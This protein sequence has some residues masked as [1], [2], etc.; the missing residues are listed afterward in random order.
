MLQDWVASWDQPIGA[1]IEKYVEFDRNY[2]ATLQAQLLAIH[3]I[4]T[5]VGL[6]T[7]SRHD[8]FKLAA[9]GPSEIDAVLSSRGISAEDIAAARA[10]VDA[11]QG[12]PREVPPF[13]LIAKMNGLVSKE[14][15]DELL[16]VQAAARIIRFSTMA[17]EDIPALDTA[18]QDK[19]FAF[20]GK[21]TSDKE[22]AYL[23]TAQSYAHLVLLNRAVEKHAGYIG[24]DYNFSTVAKDILGYSIPRLHFYNIPAAAQSVETAIAEIPPVTR[25]SVGQ[26]TLHTGRLLSQLNDEQA[27]G[28]VS[29][30]IKQR[31][32]TINTLRGSA[33]LNPAMGMG[34]VAQILK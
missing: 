19:R 18:A 26:I 13:G 34:I 17:I 6:P 33:S 12:M 2:V 22:P 29:D 24:H 3:S 31:A 20:I 32:D 11:G 14:V 25:P 9:Q 10:I 21:N 15:C 23:E 4:E 5:K 8:L 30:M 16:T 28:G 27:L 1:L 7:E